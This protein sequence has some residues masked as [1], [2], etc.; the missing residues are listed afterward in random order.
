[1]GAF[2]RMVV[3][4]T[5]LDAIR[6]DQIV[7]IV[8]VA[9]ICSLFGGITHIIPQWILGTAWIARVDDEGGRTRDSPQSWNRVPNESF[10]N[11]SLNIGG[12]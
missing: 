1:M 11:E 6:V 12:C 2:G 7:Q 9:C 5:I 3:T 10:A 4:T 8:I